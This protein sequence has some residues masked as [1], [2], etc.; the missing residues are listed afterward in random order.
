MNFVEIY[1]IFLQYRSG[2]WIPVGARFSAPVE[3]GCE[4]HPASY[5]MGTGSFPRLKRPVRGVDHPPLSSAEFKDR[6]ELYLYSTSG[7]SWPVLEWTLPFVHLVV[8]RTT[9]PKPLPK[10]ALHI[11]RSRASSF[12]WEY[13][14]LPLRSSSSFLRLLPRL[15]VT[16]ILPLIFPSIPRRRW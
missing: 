2:D 15:P 12:K 4:A 9:G 14:L 7:P 8:C 1:L 16:S 3:T 6:V 11:V 5:T 13:P 10:R